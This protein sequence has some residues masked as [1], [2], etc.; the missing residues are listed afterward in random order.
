ME[1]NDAMTYRRNWLVLLTAFIVAVTGSYLAAGQLAS[2]PAA[3]WSKTLERADRVAELRTDEV[4]AK[5]GLTPGQVVADL[6]AGTG[7]FAVPMAKAVSPKGTVYAVEIDKGY[8]DIIAAKARE[9]NVSNLQSVLGEVGDPKLPASVDVAFFH[10]VLHHVE[11]REGY[12]KNLARYV[13]PSGRVVIIDLKADTS[14][15]K[16]QPN[17][18]VT[19]GQVSGWMAAAGFS[20]VEKVD[21]FPDKFFLVFSR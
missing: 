7:L 20:R 13:K 1:G 18:I 10:D 9:A 14:P 16:D 2:R 15:H 4:I 11:S 21:L 17:L 12:L 6:G 8:F 5:I 3:E 19:E